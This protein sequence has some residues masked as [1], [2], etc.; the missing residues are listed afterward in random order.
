MCA[1]GSEGALSCQV[2]AAVDPDDVP[3][4]PHKYYVD[5]IYYTVIVRPA[6]AFSNAFFFKGVDRGLVD[7]LTVN[8][9]GWKVPWTLG[10]IGAALQNGRVSVYAWILLLGAMAVLGAIIRS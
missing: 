1:R 7:G 3:G 9:F 4:H 2:F 10:R 8:G 5:E 6:Y